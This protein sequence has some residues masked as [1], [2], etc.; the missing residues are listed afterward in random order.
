MLKLKEKQI[1]QIKNAESIKSVEKIINTSIDK[2]KKEGIEHYRILNYIRWLDLALLL[3]DRKELTDKQWE[4]TKFAQQIL[5][6]KIIYQKQ[7]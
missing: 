6:N 4:N 3:L 2:M 7:N 5:I 1:E